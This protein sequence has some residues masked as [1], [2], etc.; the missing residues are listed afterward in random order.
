M[1]APHSTEGHGRNVAILHYTV[2]PV[3]GGVGIVVEQ[4]AIG[5]L[6]ADY[7]VHV[8]AGNR[9]SLS[10]VTAHQHDLYGSTGSRI[11]E[12]SARLDDGQI[13]P[14][15]HVLIDETATLLHPILSRVD[16]VIAH[17]ILTQHRN[18]ALTAAL[19]RLHSDG[20]IQNLV[21][22]CHDAAFLDPRYRPDLHPGQPWDLLKHA[23]PATT[24]VTV[25]KHRRRQLADLMRVPQERLTVIPPGIDVQTLLK[26]STE[27]VDLIKEHRLLDARP[28]LLAPARLSRRKHLE[29]AVDI[30]A[31][32]VDSGYPAK[33]LI[34][35]P[36]GTQ[37]GANR[38]Y[39]DSLR[40]YA[41]DRVP[42]HVLF[43]HDTSNGPT[44]L[45]EDDILADLY[46]ICDA[47]LL[48]SVDEGFGMPA[49]ESTVAGTTVFCTDIP[50]FRETMGD[51]AHYF[52][53]DEAPQAVA[54]R[55]IQT[56]SVDPE[57]LLR[58]EHLH[59]SDWRHVNE[60]LTL[61]LLNR[62]G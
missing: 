5:L 19:W 54:N 42:G 58:R 50:P 39:P 31:A 25:S 16:V 53:V 22:W 62:L 33:L 51:G 55:L 15:F 3:S 44:R 29:H 12:A 56:L 2:P 49:V 24:Y 34:T 36:P 20:A 38:S 45:V 60:N 41:R 9:C 46:R 37:H 6:A 14:G 61:P 40:S 30:T 18:L 7:H 52:G 57:R 28:L 23:W 4:Q 48:T 47:T 1:T 27:T 59:R 10:G 11:T 21:A 43:L 32:L 35:G 26:L 17:N 13:E 8:L